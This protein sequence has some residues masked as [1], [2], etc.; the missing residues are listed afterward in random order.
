MTILAPI[1]LLLGAPLAALLLA[2]RPPTRLLAW[3]RAL[4]LAAVVLGL[5]R[6]AVRL[7]GRTGTVVVVA[8]RSESMEAGAWR[9]QEELIR[10]AAGG[11]SA[12]ERL[13]VVAFGREAVLE[14]PPQAGAF[15]GFVSAVGPGQSN[16]GAALDLAL[17]LIP[18]DGVGRVFVLSDGRWSGV[19]PSGPAARAAA[20]GVPVDFRLQER[21]VSGDLAIE[22]FPAPDM[23]AV[24]EAFLL[25][26][27]V[28]SPTRQTVRYELL[29]G[30]TRLAAGARECYAG[31]NRFVFRDRADGPGTRPYVLRVEAD[32][33]DPQPGNN[34]ARVLVGVSGNLPL[35]CVSGVERGTF[36]AFLR[37]GGLEVRT[38]TPTQTRWTLAELSNYSGVLL[39][40]VAAGAIG[41]SG[42]ELLAAWIE[43]TGAGLM[44]TGGRNAYGPGGYFRS[45]LERIMPVSMELKREHR[46]FSLAIVIAMDRSGS[47]A[48]GAGPGRTKMDLANLGAV[49]VM[50]LLSGDDE[51]G[52]IAV[53]STA[54]TVVD[55]APV[56]VNR[57]RRDQVLQVQS[58]GGGIFVYE[59][60]QAATRMLLKSTAQTRHIILFA[61]AADS[62][63]P[64]AYAELLKKGAG[65]NITCSVVGLG[66]EDDCDAGLLRD[67]ARMG[68]GQSFF[69]ADA[70]EIPRLF[71]QDTFA[72]TRSA[73][74]EEP[75]AVAFTPGYGLLSTLTPPAP[76]PVIGGY[77]LCYARPEANL[78]A[79][80]TDTY[81]APVIA[82]WQAGRG[83]VVC[84]TGEADGPYTGPM[85]RWP[86]VSDCFAGLARWAAGANDVLPEGLLLTQELRAGA[87]RIALHLDP[88]RTSP[89]FAGTPRV[90]MLHG[91]SGVAPIRT[92]I[93]MGWA[94]ADRMEAE[95]V[96]SGQETALPTVALP[97]LPAMTL[98]P[99]CLPYSPEFRPAEPGRGYETLK[100]LAAATGGEERLDVAAIWASLPT[101]VRLVEVSWVCYVL[102]VVLLLAD[103]LQRRTGV[104]TRGQAKR[105]RLPRMAWGR[106]APRVPRRTGAG[107]G[108]APRPPDDAPPRPVVPPET[109]EREGTLDALAQARRRARH[110]TERL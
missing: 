18:R 76:A 38:R 21:T 68:E 96:L 30:A 26:A 36:D 94:S 27:W 34:V 106:R 63:E 40:N 101:Q 10:I 73:L 87:C 83:R 32:G 48:A 78:A 46:K 54:H 90:D 6:L 9:N 16:L 41:P 51:I 31:S 53:D 37:A 39:E 57:G 109:P 2:Y 49:Q 45:P 8:D 58:M 43:N 33:E 7:P 60:L 69:T 99:V 52:V 12:R 56:D 93:E 35:L 42:M 108:Q 88:A 102:A 1:W 103:V 75:T 92:Q 89:P 95:F 61:D 79:V 4:T 66:T 11:T 19:D 72:V 24:G 23:P 22:R 25:T 44:M 77:N 105:P 55:L 29:C 65:A 50:D 104:F 85:A 110:R 71:A 91:E 82:S 80:T 59:A 28:R 74:I 3:L 67:V 81:Q 15:G 47:M 107:R 98:A 62:E 5:S 70:T 86:G 13:A 100:R 20:R 84:Y 97:G 64:G 17:G 14:H